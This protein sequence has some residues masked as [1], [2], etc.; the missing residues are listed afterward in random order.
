MAEAQTSTPDPTTSAPVRDRAPRP[1]GLFPRN[2]QA[3][4][5]AGVAGLIIVVVVLT[6]Q[7]PP[8]KTSA[9]A[10]KAPVPTTVDPNQGRIQE[11]RDRIDEQVRR[12]QAEQAELARAKQTFTDDHPARRHPRD[13]AGVSRVRH[14]PSFPAGDARARRG[15]AGV[16]GTLRR[17]PRVDTRE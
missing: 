1:A 7:Q 3:W 14:R 16:P 5:V 8:A 4:F 6:G 13:R 10:Q 9:A 17:Q 15:S 11:Y 12:L 2:L